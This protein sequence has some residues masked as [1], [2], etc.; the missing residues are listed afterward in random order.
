VPFD[1]PPARPV[2]R[3]EQNLRHGFVPI[4]PASLAKD[5]RKQSDLAIE[6]SKHRLHVGDD[7]FDLDHERRTS[8][9]LQ[10]EHVDRPTLSADLKR[11]LEVHIP[12][13]RRQHGGRPLNE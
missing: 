10:G 5:D 12:A 11:D 1:A 4:A 6:A 3:Q 9:R 8:G 7:R 2:A 13:S